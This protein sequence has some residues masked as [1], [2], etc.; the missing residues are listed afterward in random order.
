M[1]EQSS[2]SS[3]KLPVAA[4]SRLLKTFLFLIFISA[5]VVWLAERILSASDILPQRY[6]LSR[7]APLLWTTVTGDTLLAVAYLLIAATLLRIMRRVGSN[8]AYR[9]FFWAFGLFLFSRSATHFLEIM[10][11][12]YPLR[13]LVAA[14]KA[15]TALSSIVI[16]VVLMLA[17]DDII[18]FIL[19]T[20]RMA[21]QRGSE[22][23]RALFMATPLAVFSFDRKGLITSWNPAAEALFGYPESEV[24]GKPNPLVPP[25]LMEEHRLL[26]KSTLEGNITR[27]YETV[28]RH[29]EGTR[30]PVNA[31]SAP[32]YDEGGKQTGIMA[33][34]E[35]ISQR[36]RMEV[37]L[38][39]K[40]S[41]LQTVT[42]ALNS[43]LESGNWN[44]ASR[45]L[46][47][48]AIQQTESE[49][50]FVGVVL[51]DNRLRILAHDGIVWNETVNRDFYDQAM[52]SYRENGYL[53]FLNLHNLFGEVIRSGKTVVANA[54]AHDSRSGGLPAGHP[55]LNAF[56][57][58]PIF[59]GNEVAGLIGVANRKGGYT[60][61]EWRRL[62]TL[63]QAIGILYDN[64]RQ[65]LRRT[66]LEEKQS[67]LE[68]HV[69]QSQNMELLGRVAGGIAHDFNNTLMIL[70][71]ASELLERSLGPDS[72]SRIYVEEIQ[73]AVTKA[74]AITHQLLA[75]SRKQVLEIRPMDL[76]AALAELRSMLPHLLGPEI[77][78]HF[79]QNA[80]RSWIRSDAPQIVQVVINLASNARDAMPEGGTLTISTRNTYSPPA[81]AP[82]VS[83]ESRL[84]AEWLVLEVKDTGIGM[85]EN[86]LRQAFEPFFTT[87]NF[88]EASGLGLSTVYGVVRQSGG[89]VQVRSAPGAGTSFDIYFPVV[90]TPVAE[91]L[92]LAPA[93]PRASGATVLLVDDETALVHSIGEFLRE[94]GYIVLDAF[95]PQ[96]ALELAREHPAAI[97]ILVSDVVMP[98]M[99]GPE[100]Y[101][102]ILELQ[103]EIQVLFMSGYAEGLA[104]MQLPPGGLFLQK[105]F[106]FS[107]LLDR[108]RE[109]VPSA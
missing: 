4:P 77:Q 8:L 65:S 53:E 75:F 51:D 74:A 26:L 18:G 68:A 20:R 108:L 69:R 43:Y 47:A 64:Y 11:I 6:L 86:T 76:H 93:A 2:S 28:R 49:Y 83:A 31:Y 101:R 33:V 50:G 71:G 99:R 44:L 92:P 24:I 30:I 55:P 19:T 97:D 90:P 107:A 103:P 54:P 84:A 10:A 95:S 13:G 58:V 22:R 85:D 82:A 17:T 42:H 62:E 60:G 25:G 34:L 81:S 59:R 32:L 41:I 104:E 63:S 73:R 15:V 66:A 80:E 7:N 37:E 100:L 88:G 78:L 16:A 106:R 70:S 89:Y 96:A 9:E 105:P 12:W 3:A 5:A 98:G 57:G 1:P 91:V 14:A 39:E 48:F 45:E 87:K 23:F 35:D 61:S 38:G 102:H 21:A 94:S 46:L 40:T 72:L 79:R 109:L 52:R 56:L 29:R 67:A 36:R 27:A